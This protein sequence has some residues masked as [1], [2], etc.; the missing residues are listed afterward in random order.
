MTRATLGACCKALTKTLAV[1][2]KIEPKAQESGTARNA[3]PMLR[4]DNAVPR[5]MFCV[6]DG[7]ISS[8]ML[9]TS[10]WAS[11]IAPNIAWYQVL[12]R[13]F[14]AEIS[15]AGTVLEYVVWIT[16]NKCYSVRNDI[17]PLREGLNS[18]CT[19]DHDRTY[20]DQ[21]GYTQFPQRLLQRYVERMSSMLRLEYG[22][23]ECQYP[24]LGSRVVWYCTN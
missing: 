16:H 17:G 1:G 6:V 24:R 11:T 9:A 23:D 7:L 3:R 4:A 19:S 8:V 15:L 21:A 14:I 10:P 13:K 20:T 22:S 2:F 5:P 12:K 18:P